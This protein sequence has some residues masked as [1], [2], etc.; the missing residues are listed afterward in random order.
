MQPFE[1]IVPQRPLSHQAKRVA[2]KQAWKASVHAQANSCWTGSPISTGA[3]RFTMVY[4][5]EEDPADINNLIKPVQDALI[6]LVYTDDDLVVDV[7]GHLRMVDELIDLTGLSPT[8]QSALLLGT[9][10]V[11]VRVDH[12]KELN[13]QL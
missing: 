13:E 2:H 4:L 9:D 11:Y 7:Q 1:F 12:S 5:C 6:G 10:C 8:L 3:L